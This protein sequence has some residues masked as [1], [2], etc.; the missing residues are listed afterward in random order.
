MDAYDKFKK[1]NSDIFKDHEAVY[2]KLPTGDTDFNIKWQNKNGSSDKKMNFTFV[3]GYFMISGDYGDCSLTWFNKN[4][5]IDQLVNFARNPSYFMS[6]LQSSPN[7]DLPFGHY[8]E[9]DSSQCVAEVKRICKEHEVKPT[10]KD[11]EGHSCDW[12]DWFAYLRENGTD[13]FGE[14]LEMSSLY[15]CGATKSGRYY[16]MPFAVGKAY[17]YLYTNKLIPI[18]E[19][20]S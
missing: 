4:L 2:T 20:E 3:D 15:D 16:M 6:K 7:N 11:W 9:W 1:R 10:T 5:T 19:S 14:Y 8:G 17:E 12:I 18:V 13:T